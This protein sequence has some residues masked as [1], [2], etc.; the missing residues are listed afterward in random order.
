MSSGSYNLSLSGSTSAQP[1]LIH[2]SASTAVY[3]LD[4]IGIKV[5]LGENPTEDQILQLV[6][7]QNVSTYLPPTCQRRQVIDVKGFKG[8]P[9]IHFS[10]VNG[11]TL[12]DWLMMT[13]RRSEVNT[14][15]R[16]QVA[17]AVV[18]T[19]VDFHKANVAYNNLSPDN[20]VLDTSEGSYIATFIDLSKSV[21]ITSNK[22]NGGRPEGD[23]LENDLQAL[24]RTLALL[25]D[26]SLDKSATDG[27]EVAIKERRDVSYGRKRNKGQ[28]QLEGLPTCLR[29]LVSTLLR[30]KEGEETAEKY[31]NADDVLSDL[32]V[33]AAN[34]QI[35][36]ETLKLDKFTLHSRLNGPADAFYGRHSEV[37]LLYQAFD[38]VIK[39]G[40]QPIVVA[41][42]GSP[43]TG[44]THL[45]NRTRK[46]L[47]EANGYLIR[48]KF[49]ARARPDSIIFLALDDFFARLIVEKRKNVQD[50]IQRIRS[51][52]GSGCRALMNA[53]PNLHR[54]MEGHLE[55]YPD[56]A[57]G[58]STSE[59][60][61]KY[62]LCKL[63][64]A[65]SSRT[66]P[67]V[68]FFD[69]LQVSLI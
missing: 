64:S 37:S 67:L 38:S 35:F 20:V 62:L 21:I 43:G 69:D 45:A 54:F 55:D 59:H 29:A 6:H 47:E 13:Q 18:K 46:P 49:D 51:A 11:S 68:I 16:L 28:A 57:I 32:H 22:N 53:I 14:A 5:L 8:D 27:D 65:V 3:R 25:F 61:W 4:D 58:S 7:E 9:A 24:G 33:I 34:P 50:L 40:G 19:L 36:L 30:L 10:W 48:G 66:E 15:V 17:I 44:K 56:G 63:V 41:I 23:A 2:Q 12:A 39:P 26:C 60:R 31:E 52:V 1:I 42:S